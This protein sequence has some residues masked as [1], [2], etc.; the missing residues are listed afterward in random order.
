MKSDFM[1]CNLNNK[2]DYTWKAIGDK[3]CDKKNIDIDFI[4]IISIKLSK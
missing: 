2:F 3:N 1:E 4:N